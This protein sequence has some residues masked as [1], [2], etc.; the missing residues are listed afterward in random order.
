M[1]GQAPGKDGKPGLYKNVAGGMELF[2]LDTDLSETTNV[3]A[4]HPDVVRRLEGLADRM[5]MDLGDS[6][7]KK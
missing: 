7:R 5:R 3:A 4:K 6:L 2:N 1:Q